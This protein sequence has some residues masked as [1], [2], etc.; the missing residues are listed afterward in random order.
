MLSKELATFVLNPLQTSQ[1]KKSLT[2]RKTKTDK[3]DAKTIA[4]ILASNLDLT[5]YTH[6]AFQNEELKSL[7]RY[8]FEKVRQRAKLK[9]SLA[10]L[11]NI[12]F[13]E[14]ESAVSTL[15]LNC[16]YAMLLK[17]PSAKDIA[18]S[19]FDT[20][21][22]LI[23]SA[24]NGRLDK[25]K[26]KE[27]RNLARKSVGVYISAKAMELKHTITLIQVLDSEIEEIE[28]QIQTTFQDSPITTIPG[29]S[30]KMAA[31][32]QAEIGDFTPDKI[33]AFAGLS[34]TT[35]QS[36]NFVS[37]KAKMDKRGS[38]YLRYA[39]FISAQYVSMWCP[40]FKDYYQKKRS[41]G[42]HYFVALSHVAKKLIRSVTSKKLANLSKFFL[43][44]NS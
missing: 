29:I 39:L 7:T 25:L 1:F 28:Q 44:L 30:F 10:R 16:I 41:E 34:P 22:N 24:S 15:H 23:E 38:R 4:A 18:K 9:Q 5:P 36:G 33:L 14:L 6:A 35:Y 17:Y 42:K 20:F 43:T 21:A 13:P 19:R 32:I 27:I 37:S 40:V 3:V 11:C 8:R 26:A 12:L 2:L 31:M